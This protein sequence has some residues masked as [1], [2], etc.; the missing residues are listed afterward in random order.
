MDPIPFN[1]QFLATTLYTFT[2]TGTTL[3]GTL[4]GPPANFG[5]AVT[6]AIHGTA[7]GGH[8]SFT[9]GSTL[10]EGFHPW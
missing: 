3:N 1:S 10:Y 9:V 7:Q 5:P 4:D 6:G 2:Q 8:V